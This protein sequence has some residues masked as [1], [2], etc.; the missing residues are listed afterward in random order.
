M[1]V[2][3]SMHVK[4]LLT[5]LLF[6]ACF[7]QQGCVSD[8]EI[9]EKDGN[10]FVLVSDEHSNIDFS[11]ELPINLDLNI[12]NY[13]Y[14]YN[15][16]GTAVGDL[17]NDGL[18]DII[19]TSNLEKEVMY[20]NK[21]NLEFK[22]VSA[23]TNIDGGENSWTN[24]VS[25]I[26][27]NND[28][29]LDIY[30]SQVGTY[31]NLDCKNKLYVCTGVLED[32][33]PQYIERAEEYGIDFKGFSTQAG[34]LDYDLDG[35][36]DMF[37][38]NHSLHHN[39]TFGKRSDFLDTYNEVSGDRFYRNDG[40]KFTNVTEQSGIH[41]SVI[42]YGLGFAFGDVNNDGYPDIYV[43]NDFHEND[44]LYIN[45]G[46]GTFSDSLTYKIKH[47]S[48]FS[49]GVEIA[50]VNDDGYQD[51]ISLDMLPEDPTILKSSE[52]EDALD[53]FNFK[54]GYGYNHQY[55]KNALQLNQANGSFKEIASYA[56]IHATDWSW[57]PLVFD[58][59][60][61]GIKD[62]FISNG[63]PRRMNDIDYINFI[64]GNEIQYKIQFDEMDET[65]LSALEKIPQIELYNK[66]YNGNENIVYDDLGK[67]IGRH[68]KSY[69]NSAAYADFD[70]DGDYDLVT[71]NIDQ[72]AFLYE[73]KS[74]QHA[75]IRIKLNGSDKNKMGIG[76]QFIS[77]Y[78]NEK[79]YFQYA[80]YKGFQ[81]CMIN[82][83]LVPKNGLDSIRMIW[84]DRSTMIKKVKNDSILVFNYS[85]ANQKYIYER[86][87]DVVSFADITEQVGLDYR[88]QENKFVE[89]NREALI[90]FSTSAE[91]PALAVGDVNGDGLDDFFIGSS[92]RKKSALYLQGTNG[93]FAV[94]SRMKI[95][96][97]YEEVDAVFVDL[98]QDEDLDLLIATGGNEYR[99]NSPYTRLLYYENK[100]GIL[101]ENKSMFKD[102]Q[103]TASCL[104]ICDYDDDGDVDIF[105]GGRAIPWKYGEIPQSYLLENKGDGKF[106]NVISN[107]MEEGGLIGF[108]KDA[109]F[110]DLDK[111][112]RE[113]L[114]LA[115]EW[116]VVTVYY[117]RGDKFEKANISND[118]GW[119]NSVSIEDVDGDGDLD[120]FAGNL[121]K[122]ARL[123]ASK[124]R[125]VRMYY[126]DFDDNG[127]S[128][129][130]LSYYVGDREIAFSNM[131]ELQKQIP[132]LKKKFLK[133]KDFAAASI[134]ELLGRDKKQASVQYEVDRMENTLYINDGK[135]NF[136]IGE[137]PIEMQFSSY[138]AGLFTDLNRDGKPD[139]LPGGNYYYC[140]VQMGRYDA[141]NGSAL[142]NNGEGDFSYI[143]MNNAPLK[144][145]V[146]NIK[147][148]K[149]GKDNAY[150]FAQ[151]NDDLV[152]LK[153]KNR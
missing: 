20:I 123:K 76:S 84:P 65:D 134:E 17:N 7:L 75:S 52:G 43:G 15:G 113:D 127:T 88:H 46:D 135:N 86:E 35:D 146:K 54:L 3:I 62:L 142:L 144:G 87:K 85:D 80:P 108:V 129:Q 28:G 143:D 22:D 4:I 79:K 131:M 136:S 111:D 68:T 16:G 59:E 89:F 10:L 31:R 55:A 27:V 116:G 114:I 53:I 101:K 56:G 38:M 45:Q 37:L 34:F 25:L 149:I 124:D 48:R 78:N 117:N 152:V 94:D 42:G 121:G 44:Y 147:P 139:L 47:T 148:I 67:K 106:Q 74:N 21:G 128:E 57:C 9:R 1:F 112:G 141:E 49:M 19:F 91:G 145:Q 23:Q 8:D 97:T 120:I 122:N 109:S 5:F 119:W 51:I 96:S 6:Y 126:G 58:F 24:G 92:K 98:D 66:F 18:T 11:N 150:L 71:N 118:L 151:N 82:E 125:P 70:L 105:V 99:L 50:D 90:P 138:Y 60:M 77:Y 69:S 61:D 33:V 140:N 26:D 104:S 95:D 132:V 81:S 137:L 133:A 2:I 29:W 36:L 73:N 130:V 30:L 83:I 63:I 93:R 12:F 72:K 14:Y 115:L 107:R 32:G 41:S 64:S 100:D 110:V 40:S 153:V 39:G 103:L 13:M 102:I